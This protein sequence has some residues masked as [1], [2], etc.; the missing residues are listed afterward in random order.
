FA[1]VSAFAFQCLAW[2]GTDWMSELPDD[3]YVAQLSIPGTHDSATGHGTTSDSNARTQQR[4]LDEQLELGI[5][6]FDFRPQVKGNTLEAHHGIINCKI[7]FDDAMKTIIGPFLDGHPDEFVVLHML[8]AAPLF[9]SYDKDKDKYVNLLTSL[10]DS[11][12]LQGKV[13]KFRRDLTVGEMRGKILVLSRDSYS[14]TSP[15]SGFFE[16]WS[17]EFNNL[18]NRSRIV[19][20]AGDD[21]NSSK[22]FVQDRANTDGNNAEKAGFM[23]NL[24]NF[25]TRHNIGNDPANLVWVINFLSSYSKSSTSASYK[26]NATYFNK[27]F[28]D[29]VGSSSYV[30]GPTG[31]VLMDFVG[32]DDTNGNAAVN[33]VIDNN[34]KYIGKGLTAATGDK[35]QF[36]IDKAWLQGDGMYYNCGGDKALPMIA[37][38][39][40]DGRMDYYCSGQSYEYSND[41]WHWGDISYMALNKGFGHPY[42]FEAY[43]NQGV[44]RGGSRS[45][46]NN[47][48]Y[49]PIVYGGQVQA[50]ADLNQDGAV[51]FLLWDCDRHGWGTNPKFTVYGDQNSR[52]FI[53]NGDGSQFS[54][55]QGYPNNIGNNKHDN[56]GCS[57]PG[58]YHRVSVAD[59]NCDGY[60]DIM[61]VTESGT[62]YENQ[63]FNWYD[64]NG[65]SIFINNGDN[66]FTR[67]YIASNRTHYATSLFGDFNCDGYPDI[68]LNGYHDAITGADGV[69]I[70][71]GYE[72]VIMVN[73]GKGN[74]S[75]AYHSNDYAKNE[76]DGKET[77]IHVLDYDQDGKMDI[78]LS[79]ST[80]N[81]SFGNNNGRDGKVAFILR[82]E[83]DGTDVK[84]SEMLTD[85]HP[86]S[87]AMARTS[88]LADFNG[89]GFVDYL[90]DGWGPNSDWSNGTYLS[91]SQGE[92]NTNY[93]LHNG[94]IHGMDYYGNTEWEEQ[95]WIT[96]GDMDGDGMLDLIS[97][98]GDSAPRVYLNRTLEGKN[99]VA[100]VPDAPTN[101]EVSYDVDTKRVT[102]TWD[103]MFTQSGS[104]A[105]YNTYLRRLED[106]T[107]VSRSANEE[108]ATIMRVPADVNT[109]KLKAYTEWS[110]FLPSETCFYD[111]LEEGTYELG[112]Q[113]VG[114][115]YGASKFTPIQFE[116]NN[117]VNG[118]DK[119]AAEDMDAPV[120]VYNTQ[121]MMIKQGVDRKDALTNLP[122]GIYIV[123]NKK[124][125]KR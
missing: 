115:N 16:N 23:T 48:D 90:A 87:E 69:S 59:V 19:G 86:S 82:N 104:K 99:Q 63:Q 5:R 117:N 53:N 18:S 37:D 22:L 125:L 92:Y 49:L 45:G 116:V 1:I 14:G 83:S 51:D 52:V 96:F 60:P 7:T 9:G 71:G 111:N 108:Y 21:M 56:W 123:G 94:V 42:G 40:G 102:V 66:T 13:V 47:E 11:E 106:N 119:I 17:E 97:P 109:G 100:Q 46:N 122:A 98:A 61:M 91:Y 75:V 44:K 35:P 54:P 79:G 101:A 2:T 70:D 95:S 29:Y 65:T 62:T 84:F 105:I 76:D 34:F 89:D 81:N 30:A 3:A 114:Y 73:D 88:I 36:R 31:I 4:P 32:Q 112:I 72:L 107:P 38:F 8:Y 43:D 26:T 78:L 33:A 110:S 6:A 15:F 80:N 12:E 124:M 120:N 121:G 57:L 50:F 55:I 41:N 113:S 85:L 64:A 67:R 28:V 20:E 25:S 93:D 103:K 27:Q 118:L 10:F 24:L 68:V 77:A 74:F 39:D 58:K